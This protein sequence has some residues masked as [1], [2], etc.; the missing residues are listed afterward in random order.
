MKSAETY[1]AKK[2]QRQISIRQH[3]SNATMLKKSL[4]PTKLEN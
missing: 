4:L 2:R 3:T 1:Q